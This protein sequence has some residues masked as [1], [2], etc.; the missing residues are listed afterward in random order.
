V[1]AIDPCLSCTARI[2]L[3]D[4]DGRDRGTMDWDALREHGRRFYAEGRARR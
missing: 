2:V 3:L 1:A 4:P